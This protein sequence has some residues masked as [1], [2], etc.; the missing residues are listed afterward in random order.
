MDFVDAHAYWDHPHF[1]RRQ[2]DMKDWE[3]KNKP[4]VDD[5][6]GATLWGLAATRVRGKPF[7]VTEYNHAAPNEW[8]AECVPMIV[9]Y[10]ALQDWDAVFLFDYSGNANYRKQQTENFFS[11]EG[12]AAKMAPLPLAARAFLTGDL[13]PLAGS[14]V[15]QPEPREM[16]DTASRYF[17]QQWPFL[18]DVAHVKWE[19]A[20]TNRLSVWF[21][22]KPLGPNTRPADGRIR[23]TAAGPGTGRFVVADPAAAVFVGFAKGD[24]PVDLGPAVKLTK[25]DSPFA[26]IQLVPAQPGKTIADADRLLISAVARQQNTDQKWDEKRTGLSDRWGKPPE[27]VEVVR[28][29]L[30]IATTRPAEVWALGPDGKRTRQIP[31]AVK[32]GRLTVP[33]G[34][35]PTLW[36][37][38]VRK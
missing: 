22:T 21:V 7:T 32:D 17:F 6:A 2:W 35:E 33:L 16:L 4:M 8:Q 31:A 14:L 10:A 18:R 20:L 12:N 26:T 29:E 37:E 38:V 36:Y 28:G 25:L 13:Q 3:I 34:A 30:S 27:R 1:P 11:I 15:V 5:P 23:W 9:A 19:D 24:V